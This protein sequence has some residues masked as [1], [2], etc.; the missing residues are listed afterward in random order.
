MKFCKA[1]FLSLEQGNVLLFLEWSSSAMVL[2][3]PHRDRRD[4][5]TAGVHQDSFNFVWLH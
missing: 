5:G 3:T 1:I 4:A 2:L